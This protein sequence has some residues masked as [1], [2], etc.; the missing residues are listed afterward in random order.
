M[1]RIGLFLL[2]GA[3]V[4]GVVSGYLM[5]PDF[6]SSELQQIGPQM[7]ALLSV[8]LLVSAGLLA[9][10][11]AGGEVL[12]ATVFWGGLALL[13][14]AL[15]AY[16]HEFSVIKDRILAELVPGHAVSMA[17]GEI[18][19]A[20]AGNGQ[21]MLNAQVNGTTLPFLVDTGASHI[22]LTQEDAR[23]AGFP[24]DQLSYR[25]PVETA[26]GIGYVAPVRISELRI[27]D[28]ALKEARAFVAQA[29]M[30]ND[31][32]LGMSTLDRFSGIRVEG[33][34]MILTPR[35]H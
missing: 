12:K 19:I 27:N 31:S 25:V 10:R 8:L 24:V 1:V 6:H 9:R 13:L 15:Y 20:R 5:G 30:L 26:N 33:D 16:R 3:M 22:T 32:L 29:G 4:V 14:V 35:P 11:P 17:G 21:F 7:V 2:L 18:A 23:S 34:R 28:I